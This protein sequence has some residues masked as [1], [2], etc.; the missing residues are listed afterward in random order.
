LYRRFH[1]LGGLKNRQ[2]ILHRFTMTP[3]ST[4]R[5]AIDIRIFLFTITT[6]MVIAF[7]TGVYF[8]PADLLS[9]SS[10]EALW[11]VT[12][13]PLVIK[14]PYISTNDSALYEP[15]GQ[16]LLVDIKNV[17]GAFLDSEERLAHAMVESVKAGG[18]TMLSYHCHKLIPSGVSCVGVLLE[19]HISFHTWPDDGVIT[20]DLFTCGANPLLPVLPKIEELFAIGENT[21]TQWSHEVRG[22][23]L[24][25]THVNYLDHS[26]DLAY[27]VLSPLEMHSKTEIVSKRSKFQQIDIWDIVEV[28]EAPSHEDAIKHNLQ[29]GDPRWLSPELATPDRLLFLDGTLQSLKSSE[30]EYHE[31]LVHPAM[32][33]HP[34]PKHVALIGG[35]EGAT[36][37][38]VLKHKTVE[39]ASM[40]ELDE[41]LVNV[42]REFLPFM[43]DCSD[44]VGSSAPN[45]FD[46]SRTRLIFQDGVKWFIDRY[47]PEPILPKPEN[48]FDVIILDALDPE[49]DAQVAEMLYNNGNFANALLTSLSE[50]GV[51]IIQ[52]G[53]APNIHEP[54]PD[55]GVYKKRE[56]MFLMLEANENVK[57]MFTYEEAHC[58]FLEPHAFLVVCKSA[59]CRDLWYHETDAIDYKIYERI[60][61]TH[62]KERALLHYDGATH[63]TYRYPPKAWETVYCRREPT[64]F[65]CSYIALDPNAEIHEYVFDNEEAG[66]FKIEFS[67]PDNSNPII[68]ALC[69]IPKGS[70]IMPSHLASSLILE[71]IVID[72]LR[73]NTLVDGNVKIIS[74]VF[75]F[76]DRYGHHSTEDGLNH[77]YVELGA[78]VL[79]PIDA[80]KAN[81]GRWMPRRQ[82]P[83]FSPVYDRHHLSFDLFLVAKRDILKGE[84]LFRL[85]DSWE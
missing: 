59:S 63:Y 66:S 37:R 68:T 50:N 21:V 26:S 48:L 23:R 83:V 22:F 4:K 79:I 15:S 3:D 28:D 47:G 14:Q 13:K 81:V 52:V 54:R 62:S 1:F 67:G 51:L 35:G 16:H 61:R 53:T 36:L 38:E 84:E 73:K 41:E 11:H 7:G 60:V 42:S 44:F 45:C 80:D 46:N 71:G 55:I 64:P 57:A 56:K 40:I 19:S 65:E 18:L 12:E 6:A 39:T 29:P 69:D 9:T 85:P 33:A 78:S 70:Y 8:G 30:H 20:L 31:A 10:E 58:G 77:T 72:N 27:W 74:E 43:N 32:F 2:D 49:D 24:D 5:Y 34:G 17:E 76:V 75:D 82:R 25:K